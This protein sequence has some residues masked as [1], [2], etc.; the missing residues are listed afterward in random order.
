MANR[1]SHTPA[2]QPVTATL[3]IALLGAWLA[4]CA[5]QSSAH[6]ETYSPLR[7]RRADRP[8]RDP[9][10][11]LASGRPL[12]ATQFAAGG[13]LR[14]VDATSNSTLLNTTVAPGQSI[15]VSADAG[16]VVGERTLVTGP[17]ASDHNY[18][19]WWDASR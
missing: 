12:L 17:L 1:H 19:I 15:A 6:D 14:I 10:T 2:R 13:N 7:E 11:L 18:E 16:I 8:V 3:L 9:S 4:G 5:G